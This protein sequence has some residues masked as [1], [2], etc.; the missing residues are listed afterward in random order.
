MPKCKSWKQLKLQGEYVEKPIAQ[1]K[2]EASSSKPRNDKL[3]KKQSLQI[4][5]K[6]GQAFA[7]AS[8][9]S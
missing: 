1:N 9:S 2:A 4:E 6:E 3:P 7:T 8:S 5:K